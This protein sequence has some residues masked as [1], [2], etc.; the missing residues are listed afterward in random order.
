MT[1]LHHRLKHQL[2]ALAFDFSHFTLDAFAAHLSTHL[3]RSIEFIPLALPPG[4]YGAWASDKDL[5]LEYIFFNQTLSPLHQEHTKLHEL[6][7][8]ILG[9]QTQK[10]GRAELE[11]LMASGQLAGAL[12]RSHQARANQDEYE[13]EELAAMIRAMAHSSQTQDIEKTSSS[14]QFGRRFLSDILCNDD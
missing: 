8:L 14:L 10:I 2:D 11:Q 4:L 12:H 13:A 1:A 3:G 5:P 6:A 7:H 9:H